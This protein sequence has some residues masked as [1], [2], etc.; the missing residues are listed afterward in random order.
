MCFYGMT[1]TRSFYTLFIAPIYCNGNPTDWILHIQQSHSKA[2]KNA[3]RVK[4]LNGKIC[5][6]DV[7]KLAD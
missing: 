1:E 3:M 4:S 6:N 5:K 2:L 7:E